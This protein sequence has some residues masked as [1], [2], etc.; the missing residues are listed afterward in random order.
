MGQFCWHFKECTC[1]CYVDLSLANLSEWDLEGPDTWHLKIWTHEYTLLSKRE[2]GPYWGS[3]PGQSGPVGLPKPREGIRD[4]CWRLRQVWHCDMCA[5]FCHGKWERVCR[6]KR[7]VLWYSYVSK[8][9]G[10]TYKWVGWI[11]R[12]TFSG[13]CGFPACTK[14]IIF[15]CSICQIKKFIS[16]AWSF[17]CA[18]GLSL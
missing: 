18:G 6:T 9:A 11:E 3:D 2:W 13:D 14:K 4:I 1:T 7:T 10:N 17:D 16:W 12:W 5:D 15:H 8:S